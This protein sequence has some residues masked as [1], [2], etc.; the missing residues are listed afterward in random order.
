MYSLKRLLSEELLNFGSLALPSL[1]AMLSPGELDPNLIAIGATLFNIPIGLAVSSLRDADH[2]AAIHSIV[3]APEQMQVGVGTALLGWTERELAAKRC[4]SIEIMYFSDG[5]YV[6]A[7]ERI[8]WKNGW[9]HPTECALLGRTNFAT[10]SQA[11]WVKQWSKW[12][13]PSEFQ[14]FAWG[15]ITSR[16]RAGILE[17]QAERPWFPECVNPFSRDS[18]I[19]P[20]ASLGLRHN[21]QVIGWSLARRKASNVLSHSYFVEK[22]PNRASLGLA[23]L[24]QCIMLGG[25]IPAQ[26]FVF[27]IPLDSPRMVQFINQRLLP[28]VISARTIR[29]AIKKLTPQLHRLASL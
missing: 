12:A 14:V 20:R 8:L 11:P 16:E 13:I 9:S 1:R 22:Q 15:E 26:D 27:D 17:R 24:S 4:S 2:S 23:L 10:I 28:Y 25:Q 6:P 21:G 5:P 18:Q 29:R 19:E 7:L 3:V